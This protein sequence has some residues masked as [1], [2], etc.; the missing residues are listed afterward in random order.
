MNLSDL[1]QPDGGGAKRQPIATTDHATTKPKKTV[2]HLE[3][4]KQAFLKEIRSL[5]PR[6]I[7]VHLEE[8]QQILDQY[9]RLV[10]HTQRGTWDSFH[11]LLVALESLSTFPRRGA[12]VLGGWHRKPDLSKVS[13]PSSDLAVN[14]YSLAIHGEMLKR[15][16]E[17]PSHKSVWNFANQFHHVFSL[18]LEDD[19]WQIGRLESLAQEQVAKLVP[20]IHEHLLFMEDTAFIFYPTPENPSAGWEDLFCFKW[21][22]NFLPLRIRTSFRSHYL[23]IQK[24]SVATEITGEQVSTNPP[25]ISEYLEP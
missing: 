8:N 2:I 4:H 15:I 1:L 21:G 17:D 14:I 6:R 3:K 25:D 11:E 10:N 7:K 22:Y 23:I 24:P 19:Y 20:L 16:K 18:S 5:L 13:A 12:I 9:E